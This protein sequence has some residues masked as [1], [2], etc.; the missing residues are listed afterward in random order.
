MLARV[1]CSSPRHCRSQFSLSQAKCNFCHLFS[2]LF[3]CVTIIVP[4]FL[5]QNMGFVLCVGITLMGFSTC[6]CY[7]WVRAMINIEREV[8][9]PGWSSSTCPEKAAVIF[10]EAVRGRSGRVAEPVEFGLG[11]RQVQFVT[12][13][14]SLAGAVLCWDDRQCLQYS[15]WRKEQCQR[16]FLSPSDGR[17][18]GAVSC[19]CYHCTF[20]LH[21][22]CVSPFPR[23]HRLTWACHSDLR[24]PSCSLWVCPASEMPPGS[25]ALTL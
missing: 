4:A 13:G 6:L 23:L 14:L 21:A 5:K 9:L 16:L 10:G 1:S 22:P 18:G 11:Y 15:E 17:S 25:S 3:N 24:L 7:I 8:L 20:L 12:L 2:P 19:L